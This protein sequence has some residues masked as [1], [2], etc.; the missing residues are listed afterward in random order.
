M[1]SLERRWTWILGLGH[2]GILLLLLSLLHFMAIAG[3]C[4]QIPYCDS[5]HQSWSSA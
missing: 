3:I 4:T 5:F 2:V 1:A